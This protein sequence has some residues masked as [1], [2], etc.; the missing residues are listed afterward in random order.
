MGLGLWLWLGWWLGAGNW[1]HA[2][3]ALVLLLI[4]YQGQCWL[5]LRQMQADELIR[6]SV[7]FRFFNDRSTSDR[8]AGFLSSSRSNHFDRQ[9]PPSDSLTN[10]S[11]AGPMD[12]ER[13]PQE[14]H[15]PTAHP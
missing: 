9:L 6:T 7:Y 12:G 8:R 15:G 10:L 14:R 5:Y 3:L 1:M 11:M 13:T 4:G 2:K